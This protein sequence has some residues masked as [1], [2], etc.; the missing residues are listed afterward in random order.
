[1]ASDIKKTKADP[2]P[3]NEAAAKN[4][5]TSGEDVSKV[6]GG[7]TAGAVIAGA[8]ARNRSARP[9]RKTGT[10]FSQRRTR[11]RKSD[12]SRDHK[13]DEWV[14]YLKLSREW[15]K[16]VEARWLSEVRPFARNR[17]HGLYRPR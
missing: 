10:R 2:A 8:K 17:R 7:E 4:K 5:R 14:I 6:E 15:S 3:K 16:A 1:M 9:T 11:R 12:N 13:I